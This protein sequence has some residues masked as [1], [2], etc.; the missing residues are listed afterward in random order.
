MYQNNFSKEEWEEI[1]ERYELAIDRIRLM[2]QENT[3]KE[4]FIEY[5]RKMAAFVML[6]K[7]IV[8]LKE[9]NSLADLAIK[10]YKSINRSLYEDITGDNYLVSYA[11]PTYACD[12]M[13]VK[14]GKLL[15]FLYT[16]LRSIIIYAYEKRLYELT[17][18]LELLIEVYNYFEAEDEF[19][20]KD[21]KRAIYDFMYDY[22]DLLVTRRIRE[23][24]DTELA[25]ATDI[26]MTSDLSDL[27][28]LYQYGDYISENEER[29][30]KF[31]NSL[32]EKQIK[33]MADTFT[34][35]YRLGFIA[36][37]LDISKKAIVNLRY[38][39]GFE[40]MVRQVIHNFE[41]MGLKPTIYRAAYNAMNRYQQHKIGYHATSPNRQYDYDHRFD[42]GIFLDKALKVRKLESLKT[43]L[44]QYKDK[45]ALYAGPSLIQV[46]GEELFAPEDKKEVI[47]LDKRQQ[48]L[49]VDY[50][51]EANFIHEKYLKLSE[52]SFTI[53]SYP[54][55]E[56]G[57]DFEAIFA[58]TVKVN[59]LDSDLYRKIQQ[60]IIN[61][62][63]QGDYVYVRGTGA[64][65]TDIKVKL[66]P[67]KD[68]EKETNF[69]NCV[70][71]VNIPVGEVFTSPQLKGTHGTLHVPKVYLHDLEYRDLEL[72]FQDGR[73]IGYN[74]K[75]FDSD[76]KN[77]SFIKENLLY[78][79]D[80]LPLG[81]FAI[82]TNTTAYMMG[83]KYDIAPRLPI[84]IA[85]KTGPHFAIGDTCYKMAEDKKVFNP[86]GKE[87]IARD[88]EIS[89]LRKTEPD[90]AYFNCHTDI[91]LPYDEIKEITVCLKDG[92]TIPI[93]KDKRFVL[94]GTQI[95][96]K[97][98]DEETME[99]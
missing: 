57:E 89:L 60:A 82:G 63:D 83:R 78:N 26:I 19:T 5:F 32:P 30:A 99:P 97:A 52:T 55:P 49:Y 22:C 33:A 28:Y 92:T 7:N 38:Q 14:Y 45:A 1:K 25:F 15:S 48:K 64:N 35:G 16:E 12:R 96:N 91:T 69:E 54:I 8:Q 6:I 20:Y 87:I 56:I 73:V 17:I 13:G 61:A 34:E 11:N 79:H 2:E 18:Y 98:F 77:K 68:K 23:M 27:K 74:C 94:E 59:T 65:R 3:V 86:D 66:H 81:E 50:Y 93:I 31:L 75:N 24:I 53:I 39:I 51:N 46:F 90:K 44:E 84:L 37:N 80:T 67:L 70:A 72:V 10:E 21:V 40:R 47:R 4:P 58:E 85:E 95:L 29:T 71:D 36:N 76:E 42:I 62:L 9:E 43:G 41:K 88:N